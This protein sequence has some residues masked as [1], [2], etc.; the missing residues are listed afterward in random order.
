MVRVQVA[1]TWEEMMR[2]PAQA[3]AAVLNRLKRMGALDSDPNR[4]SEGNL[5]IPSE[6]R[7]VVA[8]LKISVLADG[9]EEAH[10]QFPPT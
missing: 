2:L 3:H 5:S 7:D 6:G 1:G 10:V 4:S 8:V 9:T